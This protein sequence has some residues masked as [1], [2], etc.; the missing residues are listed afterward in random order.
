M[1]NNIITE[2]A[3]QLHTGMFPVV[4]GTATIKSGAIL[5]A[6]SVL[7]LHA[8]GTSNIAGEIDFT[9]I[10]AILLEDVDAS[11][12]DTIAPVMLTGEFNID[13]LIFK[14]SATDADKKGFVASARKNS[15]F[16]KE[17]V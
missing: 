7:G 10:N 14:D 15:I 17:L 3:R 4:A 8:D 6:R 13:Q 16:I 1:N 2:E 5:A 11:S 12:G 9:D